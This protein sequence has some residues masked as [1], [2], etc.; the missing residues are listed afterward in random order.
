MVSQDDKAALTVGVETIEESD[1][2]TTD[3]R[4]EV[5]VDILVEKQDMIEAIEEM[6]DGQYGLREYL[7]ERVMVRG[8]I[9]VVD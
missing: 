5:L 7:S 1:G 2:S 6:A 3:D 8:E 9:F 4:Q